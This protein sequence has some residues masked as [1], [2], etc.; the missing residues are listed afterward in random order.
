MFINHQPPA[1]R[2][3][4]RSIMSKNVQVEYKAKACFLALLIRQCKIR[5]KKKVYE[6]TPCTSVGFSV[7]SVGFSVDFTR[8]AA[9]GRPFHRQSP[10]LGGC[11]CLY[12]T[13]PL[14]SNLCI[15]AWQCCS[16]K[17]GSMKGKN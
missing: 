12:A 3:G 2:R 17:I 15:A 10:E 11:P 1:Y 16:S 13:G 14:I 5:H 8:S 6:T 9:S 7:G 4:F